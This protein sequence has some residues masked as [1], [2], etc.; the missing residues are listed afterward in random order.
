M[1]RMPAREVEQMHTTDVVTHFV[2]MASRCV[3]A[4]ADGTAAVVAR[5]LLAATGYAA[6]R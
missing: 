6:A 4:G 5:R 2:K 3:P 1:F